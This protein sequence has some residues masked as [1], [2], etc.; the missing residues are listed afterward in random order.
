MS[1]SAQNDRRAIAKRVFDALCA[2]FPDK[3]IALIQP[4]D[5]DGEP[6]PPTP[7]PVVAPVGKGKAPIG[8]GKGK[9]PIAPVVTKG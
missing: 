6:L 4:P 2:Q 7:R 8:K 3:Y 5:L 1:Q 9:A